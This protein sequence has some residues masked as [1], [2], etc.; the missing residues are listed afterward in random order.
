MMSQGVLPYQYEEE[1]RSGGA[2]ALGGLP[3]YL[4]LASA[5]GLAGSLERRLGIRSGSVQGWTDSE[6][7]LSL[8]LLN[9]AG[10]DCVDDLRV[11]EGDEGF[12][13]VLDRVRGAGLSR[14]ERRGLRTRWRK[15]RRRSVPSSSAVFRWLSEFHDEKQE[16]L[17]VPGKALIPQPNEHLVGLRQVNR[18][19]LESVQRRDPLKVATLDQDAT[20]VETNKREALYCY[21]HF[22]AYQPL[23]TFWAERKLV[24][25]SEFRDGNVPAGF[26]QLRVLK[27]ALDDLPSGVKKVYL[28]SDTAGYQKHLLKYCAAGKSERFGVIEFTVGA[29]VTVEFKK[30]VAEVPKEGWHRFV[31]KVN[32]KLER[33]DQ[34]WAEVCYVP[35]WVT[36]SKSGPEYRYL[37]TREPLRQL[38]LP[39]VEPQRDLPFPTMKMGSKQHYKVFGIVTN[40]D[41][42][43]QELFWWHRERCGKS[44]EVHG[45][46]K[47]D[48]AGGTLPSAC[49]G[50]N[51]AWW[52]MMILA[53]NLNEIMKRQVLGEAWAEKR[54]KAIRYWI[55]NLPGWVRKHSRRLYVRLGNGHPSLELLINARRRIWALANAPPG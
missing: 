29:D 39:G 49:F 8:I 17:R 10:G 46:M 45:V 50:A 27:E 31:R 53:L 44:E 7:G 35:D 38:E 20:L 32:G 6:I 23:N 11:L 9:L 16:G 36:H 54:L 4:D 26:E 14:R 19:L 28:R 55:I 37:A 41:L 22:K 40:R 47:D 3:L 51:A 42:P 12:C 1:S 21:K 2:T 13:R 52:G 43:G 34:Q 18:D 30:A 33:T 15:E 5:L 25:H 48:L 24:C